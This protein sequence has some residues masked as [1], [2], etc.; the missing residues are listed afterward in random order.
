MVQGINI[1]F[2]KVEPETISTL[3]NGNIISDFG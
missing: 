3:S 2:I 1:V